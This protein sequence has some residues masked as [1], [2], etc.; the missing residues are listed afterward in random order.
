MTLPIIPGGF[1]AAFSALLYQN[2]A[3][4]FEAVVGNQAQFLAKLDAN[5]PQILVKLRTSA[6]D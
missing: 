1:C 4:R 5:S 6:F 2:L 3:D